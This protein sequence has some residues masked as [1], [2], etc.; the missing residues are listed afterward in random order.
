MQAAWAILGGTLNVAVVLAL[1]PLLQGVVRKL[2]ARIQSRQGPPLL[3]P[4]FDLLKLLGKEDIESGETPGMQRFVALL[5]LATVLA[6]ACLLP[7]GFGAPM[8]LAGD[9]ILLIYLLTLCGISTLLAG[10]AAGSTYSL[11]GVSREMMTMITLEPLLAVAIIVGALHSGSLRLNAVLNGSLYMS[12]G[13]PW[14]GL[15]MAAVMLLSFQAFV[16]RVPF[17]IC[18]AET[19]LMEGPLLEYSGPKLA[20]FH[21]AQMARLIIYSAL[22]AAL[23]LPW[24]AQLPFP[25]GWLLFWVK[26]TAMVL[27]VTVIAATHA[28]YRIDQALRYFAGLLAASTVALVLAVF[29]Y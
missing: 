16:Q 18:E 24:G 9:V 10:M 3:Q 4:Y 20:L 15:I 11:I 17:D 8:N 27:L 25:L 21:Y 6:V 26:V 14:S 28:R 19:E 22:F 23:F 7:M 1:A 29:G 2:T 12:S 13:I 5:S